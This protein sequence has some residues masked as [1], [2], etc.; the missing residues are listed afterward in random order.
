MLPVNATQL[1]TELVKLITALVLLAGAIIPL[2][3]K[4]KSK[5]AKKK[6][7]AQITNKEYLH[8]RRLLLLMVLNI[9][10]SAF[11]LWA[12]AFLGLSHEAMSFLYVSGITAVALYLYEQEPASRADTV[13]LILGMMILLIFQF[14]VWSVA[15]A[16]EAS[17]PVRQGNKLQHK[18]N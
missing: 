18:P 14:G 13:V 3:L 12:I 17:R 15:I 2:A 7:A 11:S 10:A 1:T 5:R 4:T 16:N 8:L 6:E 9:I